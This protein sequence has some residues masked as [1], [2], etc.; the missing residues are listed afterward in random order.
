[1][2]PFVITMREQVNHDDA[3]RFTEAFW[4]AIGTRTDPED[5]FYEAIDKVPNVQEFAQLHC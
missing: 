2:V 1:V 4:T 5:A 3:A